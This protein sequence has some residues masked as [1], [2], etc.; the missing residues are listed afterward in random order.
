MNVTRV[1]SFIRAQ[2]TAASLSLRKMATL[3]GV[4][5]PYLSQVERGLRRPSAEILSAIAKALRISAE[6]LYVQAGILEE[7]TTADVVSA[8]LSDPSLTQKQ[9]Q[10]LVSTYQA[11]TDAAADGAATHDDRKKKEV[12]IL[13]GDEDAHEADE[14]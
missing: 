5:I 6:T 12:P 8:I 3:A 4:S 13:D 2:R 10:V 9:K 14:G 1:G 7:R 11:F